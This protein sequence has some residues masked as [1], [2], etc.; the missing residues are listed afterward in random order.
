MK[1]IILCFLVGVGFIAGLFCETKNF[2]VGNTKLSIVSIPAKK[3]VKSFYMA[4]TETTQALYSTVMGE[5]PSYEKGDSLPVNKVSWFD[6]VVFCN[7]LSELVGK[8]SVYLVDGEKNTSKWEYESG[9]IWGAITLD[10]TANGFRLPTKE[11]WENCL[12][13]DEEYIYEYGTYW[14]ANKKI[15]YDKVTEYPNFKEGELVIE[16]NKVIRGKDAFNDIAVNSKDVPQPVATK[17]PNK[18]GL[19]D[20]LGNIGEWVWAYK[21]NTSQF[22]YVE[23]KGRGYNS[24]EYVGDVKIDTIGF[25]VCCN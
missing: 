8:T 1:K 4:T 11:E 15:V 13:Y 25:R 2:S 19:Y 16:N 24:R 3:G 21:N 20:M 17:L 22:R 5:N 9:K 23:N 14:E 10:K 12:G 7:K 18:Y 6:A